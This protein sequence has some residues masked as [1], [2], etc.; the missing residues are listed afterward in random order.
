MPILKFQ[1]A[2]KLSIITVLS[3]YINTKYHARKEGLLRQAED[4]SEDQ[5]R[6]A[7]T[8]F[9]RWSWNYSIYSKKTN[10][11]KRKKKMSN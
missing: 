9:Q 5:L 4:L 8:I 6:V 1:R 2:C 11:L 10:S 7:K 3:Y